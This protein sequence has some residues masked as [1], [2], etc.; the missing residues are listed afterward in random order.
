MKKTYKVATALVAALSIAAITTPAQAA[1]SLPSNI[2]KAGVINIGI[3]ATYS[4]NEFK[5]KNG[6]VIGWE[7]DLFNAVA[8]KLGVKTNYVIAGF[9]T[10]LAGVKAGKYDVGV[11][12][13]TDTKEREASVDFVNYFNAGTQWAVKKGV[14]LD[15]NNACGKIVSA[16]TG[17]V[18]ADDISAKSEACTKAGKKAITLLTFDSGE[19]ATAAV[20]LGRADATAADS[21]VLAYAVLQTKG[22]LALAGAIFDKA[23]YGI[24]LA[25]KS[26]LAPAIQ[27]AF[28]AIKKDGTYDSILKKWGVEAGAVSKFTINGATS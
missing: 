28:A 26:T 3:D 27:Q 12:S 15:P 13:F 25:K 17:S 22:K 2:A 21:P 6:K 24:A 8:K 1:T 16:M 18:Q 14:K 5:D 23:P 10:I 9:D 19:Q 7:V 20:V 11:S 4:P